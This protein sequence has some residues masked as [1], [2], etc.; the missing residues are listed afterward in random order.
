MNEK[1]TLLIL[2]HCGTVTSFPPSIS[3]IIYYTK[4]KYTIPLI[5]TTSTTSS[6]QQCPPI[7]TII[8][9]CIHIILYTHS[10]HWFTVCLSTVDRRSRDRFLESNQQISVLVDKFKVEGGVFLKEAPAS[11]GGPG[12]N[13]I[14]DAHQT[15]TSSLA[16][17]PIGVSHKSLQNRGIKPGC[18]ST[19]FALYL[20]VV[21]CII[22]VC[23]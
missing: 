21:V 18:F 6:Q 5:S 9:I 7:N 12:S 20:L 11:G 13:G 23:V 3:Y 4:I 8:H 2:Q 19:L 22:C 10:S 15:P 17:T 14:K 1:P 16:P